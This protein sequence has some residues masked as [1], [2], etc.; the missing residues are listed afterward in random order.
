MTPSIIANIKVPNK[1]LF[2]EMNDSFDK[3]FILLE[4]LIIENLEINK[5]MNLS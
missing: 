3:V 1:I 2:I 4:G 5:S